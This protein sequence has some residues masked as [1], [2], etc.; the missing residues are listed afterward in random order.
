MEQ[1]HI[2]RHKVLVEGLSIRRVAREVGVSR[3]TV[4]KYLKMAEPVCREGKNRADGRALVDL[5]VHRAVP[6]KSAF[7]ICSRSVGVSRVFALSHRYQI[8]LLQAERFWRA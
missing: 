6:E 1:A 2:I 8:L 7:A 3:N 4:G 5:P